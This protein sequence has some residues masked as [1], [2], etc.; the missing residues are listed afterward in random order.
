VA[1]DQLGV[2]YQCAGAWDTS[3][4]AAKLLR[5]RYGNRAHVGADGDVSKVKISELPDAEGIQF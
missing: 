3:E 1:L 5:S 4:L 2:K